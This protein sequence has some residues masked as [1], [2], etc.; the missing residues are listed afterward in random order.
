MG[1]AQRVQQVHRQLIGRELPQDRNGFLEAARADQGEAQLLVQPFRVEAHGAIRQL[2]RPAKELCCALAVRHR[3]LQVTQLPQPPQILCPGFPRLRDGAHVEV[4][5][6]LP[7]TWRRGQVSHQV[8]QPHQDHH[9]PGHPSMARPRCPSLRLRRR[10][11]KRDGSGW[12]RWRD[13]SLGRWRCR[14]RRWHWHRCWQLWWLK[15]HWWHWRHRWHVVLQL[16]WLNEHLVQRIRLG[17]SPHAL[18]LPGPRPCLAGVHVVHG[19][20]LWRHAIHQELHQILMLFLLHD[21]LHFHLLHALPHHSHLGA[22]VGDMCLYSLNLLLHQVQPP[23]QRSHVT[24]V[25]W[26]AHARC[27][28]VIHGIL[29]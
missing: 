5:L 28:R 14:Q 1:E 8:Q 4:L 27:A 22:Q 7:R 16:G 25:L 24:P 2:Q 3:Q 19:A 29:R 17:F 23:A 11:R 21:Q 18:P 10:R 20:V 26:G 15:R 13:R 6:H 9:V 12:R